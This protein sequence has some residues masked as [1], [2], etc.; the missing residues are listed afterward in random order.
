MTTSTTS[1]PYTADRP[2]IP[3]PAGTLTKHGITGLQQR[4]QGGLQQ[5]IL[6]YCLAH[7]CLEGCAPVGQPNAF[8]AEQAADR[9]L[10]RDQLRLQGCTRCQQAA[11]LLRLRRLDPDRSVFID[12]H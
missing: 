5:A 11:L 3:P 10:E 2:E 9:V 8:L 7:R 1:Q 6:A 12:A 4:V